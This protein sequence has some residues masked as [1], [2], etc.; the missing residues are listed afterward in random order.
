[1]VGALIGDRNHK[2]AGSLLEPSAFRCGSLMDNKNFRFCGYHYF[3]NWKQLLAGEAISCK[4][5]KSLLQVTKRTRD[6]DF[7]NYLIQVGWEAG[8]RTPIGGFRVRSL[9]V[10][11]P[12]N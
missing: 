12:P 4:G 6:G 5:G 7:R 1:M 9:T 2:F 11:R 3:L 10:R 8:I